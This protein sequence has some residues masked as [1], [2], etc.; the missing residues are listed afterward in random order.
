MSTPSEENQNN[1]PQGKIPPPV[2][3]GD[4]ETGE[5]VQEAERSY[6]S[7]K[8]PADKP[9]VYKVR[10]NFF[11]NRDNQPI[12][13]NLISFFMFGATVWLVFYT[14]GLFHKT[15]IQAK[16]A[17]SADSIAQIQLDS[18]RS[19]K[20]QS[21]KADAAKLGRDMLF[22]NKQKRGIDAQIKAFKET[23][24]DFEIEN[25]SY[26]TADIVEKVS[27]KEN[28]PIVANFQVSNYGKPPIQ[29]ISSGQRMQ[30]LP[31]AA[32][33]KF[34][35]NPMSYLRRIESRTDYI[36]NGHPLP[37]IFSS[38]VAYTKDR[39]EEYI[40]GGE[41]LYLIGRYSYINN[42]NNKV[43]NYDFVIQ[44]VDGGYI[45]IHN[46]NYDVKTVK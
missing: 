45:Y 28:E 23:K 16:A 22:A 8:H 4:A 6:V 37:G 30:F 31:I 35:K 19:S 17:M 36:G 42:I 43:R 9:S 27:I 7:A 44:I 24:K 1:N 33:A 41:L 26:L 21:D 20:R 14:I 11:L 38:G 5:G 15:S 2:N 40:K 10:K 32:N 3:I 18:M 25:Q 12:I 13:A 39:Y 29:L 34:L 46:K